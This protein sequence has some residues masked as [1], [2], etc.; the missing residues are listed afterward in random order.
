MK[1][2]KVAF[3]TAR[4]NQTE[5]F[6]ILFSKLATMFRSKLFI[7]IKRQLS[8]SLNMPKIADEMSF[9]L[10]FAKML[11]GRHFTIRQSKILKL[12]PDTVIHSSSRKN[13]LPSLVLIYFVCIL[14]VVS[15]I[16]WT[17]IAAWTARN[18][19]NSW[20]INVKFSEVMNVCRNIWLIENS[21]CYLFWILK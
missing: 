12:S 20:P 11:K 18:F 2:E 13:V 10:N 8:W 3:L 21:N 15:C 4:E 6:Q 9:Q 7:S 19:N 1:N 5:T 17:K 16:K 14:A